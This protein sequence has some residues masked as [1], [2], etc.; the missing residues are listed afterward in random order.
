MI[1][2]PL[3]SRNDLASFWAHLGHPNVGT[4]DPDGVAV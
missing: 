3:F 1:L 2:H 4:N